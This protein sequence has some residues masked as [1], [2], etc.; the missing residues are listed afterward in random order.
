TTIGPQQVR[1]DGCL[2]TGP[3]G[4]NRTRFGSLD[5][6]VFGISLDVFLRVPL[7]KSPDAPGGKIQPYVLAGAPM[8]VTS[9]DPRNSRTFRDNDGDTDVSFGYKGGVGLAFYV[10]KN[11]MI[12]G[13]YRFTHVSPEFELRSSTGTGAKATVRTDLDTH[14]GL[15]GISARW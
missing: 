13:E 5:F 10:F 12:F 6:D 3:C 8:F 2:A 1:A 9:V 11:L 4:T 14:T 7:M 15:A